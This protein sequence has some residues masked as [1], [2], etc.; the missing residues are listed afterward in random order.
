MNN[1]NAAIGLEQM[2]RFDAFKKRKQSIVARYDEA[3]KG[4]EGIG[5]LRH[6]PEGAF[7]FSYVIKVYNGL[8]DR[9]MSFLKD[10]GI[11]TTVQF[12]P[13]H[14]QKRFAEFN[15][16]LP[17]TEKLYGEIITLPLYYE[18]VDSDIDMVISS[19]TSFFKGKR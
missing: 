7:P 5:L 9:L 19:V 6:D 16:P 4:L 8:R 15:A 18:M 3:F 17:I 11:G 1:I 12:I 2:Q 14:L 13:N 10:K